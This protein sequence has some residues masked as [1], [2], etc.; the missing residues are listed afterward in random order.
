MAVAQG[1]VRVDWEDAPKTTVG[2]EQE[3]G[4]DLSLVVAVRALVL[5]EHMGPRPTTLPVRDM[6][7]RLKCGDYETR[8][9][10]HVK[11]L[12]G[13]GFPVIRRMGDPAPPEP[14][15]PQFGV[16]A[17]ENYVVA[18]APGDFTVTATT[19]FR[20]REAPDPLLTEMHDLFTQA[21]DMQI[22][23]AVRVIGVSSPIKLSCPL[24][25]SRPFSSKTKRH[26][27]GKGDVTSNHLGTWEMV[28]VD[29]DPWA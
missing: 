3:T 7:L 17:R 29:S 9:E 5:V 16:Y 6:R 13:T 2:E 22:D 8:P 28:E 21:D 19:A 25:R 18:T 24:R 12:G 11:H 27:L 23:L 14:V 20:G 26:P 1:S 15:P 4:R 10:V